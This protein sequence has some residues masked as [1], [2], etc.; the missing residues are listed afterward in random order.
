[1]GVWSDFRV[2][3][4]IKVARIPLTPTPH[5][6]LYTMDLDTAQQRQASDAHW[7]EVAQVLLPSLRPQQVEALAVG[8]QAYLQSRAKAEQQHDALWQQLM[9]S[10]PSQEVGAGGS[11]TRGRRQC[12]V[13]GA[14]R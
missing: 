6:A 2:L 10:G 8:M 12:L 4:R 14:W 3:V 11:A 1:M 5:R 9:E 7:R 13:S